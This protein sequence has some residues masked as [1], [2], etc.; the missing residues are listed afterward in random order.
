MSP[1]LNKPSEQNFL[2]LLVPVKA[3]QTPYYSQRDADIADECLTGHHEFSEPD[4]QK[5]HRIARIEHITGANDARQIEQNSDDN[6]DD[7][8]NDRRFHSFSL[9][10]GSTRVLGAR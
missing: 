10:Y 9:L 7:E 1:E 5:E 3:K 2:A 4:S 6:G 8:K